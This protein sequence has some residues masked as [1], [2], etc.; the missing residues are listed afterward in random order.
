MDH[1]CKTDGFS[2]LQGKPCPAC[3]GEVAAVI[4]ANPTPP[5]EVDVAEGRR[6][7]EELTAAKAEQAAAGGPRKAD[8]A[9]AE[10]EA[11]AVERLGFAAIQWAAWLRVSG[12]SLLTAAEQVAAMRKALAKYEGVKAGDWFYPDGDTSS[13]AC[14]DTPEE[15]LTERY[16]A[17]HDPS[18][19]YVIERA[20][21]LPDIFAAVRVFTEEEKDKRADDEDCAITYHTSREEA[22][23]TLTARPTP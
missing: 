18:A 7:L 5:A 1:I 22:E 14:C 11:A 12:P 16:E 9:S 6:L 19:V 3:V 20:I 4:E 21:K 13:D 15:V 23:A 8:L 2:P 17:Q 10:R